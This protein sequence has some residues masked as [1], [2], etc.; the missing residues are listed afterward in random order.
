MYSA[1]GHNPVSALAGGEEKSR[2][3]LDGV[4]GFVAYVEYD[5]LAVVM[6]EPI[7]P[8]ASIPILVDRFS[9]FC[10]RNHTRPIY[11]ACLGATTHLFEERGYRVLH[12]GDDPQIP[13]DAFEPDS[14]VRRLT[15]RLLRQGVTLEEVK[16]SRVLEHD[17]V[18]TLERVSAEWQ[19]RIA[20]PPLSVVVGSFRG[21]DLE[22]RVFVAKQGGR[23]LGFLT[24]YPVP[25]ASTAYL[26]LTRFGRDAPEGLGE[27]MIANLAQVLRAEGCRALSLGFVPGTDIHELRRNGLVFRLYKRWFFGHAGF[28][29]GARGQ[30]QFKRK[31]RPTWSPVYACAAPT[32]TI[33]DLYRLFRVV[34]PA[35]LIAALGWSWPRRSEFGIS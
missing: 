4:E 33:W 18:E 31:F 6:G 3:R 15:R 32:T 28:I 2:F 22:R 35:G 9:E 1:W 8:P 24:V 17:L 11:F 20:T 10:R 13:L 16:P 5:R 25:A 23:T 14:T 12:I 26:D 30:F 21:M 27:F 19:A 7:G 29:H 34:Q